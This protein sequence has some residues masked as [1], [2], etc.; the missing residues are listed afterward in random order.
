MSVLNLDQVLHKLQIPTATEIF[1]SFWEES[2]AGMPAMVPD[3]LRPEVA[4]SYREWCG[5]SPEA[6]EALVETCKRIQEDSALMQFTWHCHQLMYKHPEY[7][8][9]GQWPILTAVLGNLAGVV[10]LLV[11]LAAT[12]Y[13]QSV[14]QKLGVSAEITR[15]TCHQVAC[16]ATNYYNM[17][18]GLF[19][20][21]LNQI[22]WLRNYTNG[23]LFRIGRF[24]YRIRSFGSWLEAY[25]NK[26]TRQV[27]ALSV[28]GARYTV[29]GY[30]AVDDVAD[31]WTAT[32]LHNQD[33]V[34]GY[35]IL[36]QGMAENRLVTLAL[37]Q[38]ER[39][40]QQGDLVLDMHIPTG[41]AMHLNDCADSFRKGVAF[42]KHFFPEKPIKAICCNN[43]WIFNNQLQEIT[44]SSD[45]LAS[46]QR[47]LYLFPIKSSVDSG[48]WFIFQQT[49]LDLNTAP[50]RTSLQRAVAD[51]I[52]SGHTWRSGGMYF[53]VDDLDQFGTQVYRNALLPAV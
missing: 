53:L 9:T 33:T 19:G 38:W 27:I 11:G 12:P 35:P 51:Y 21:T 37:D 2:M 22:Y 3:F 41:G 14:H 50:R 47:E 32:L 44:L 34:A 4:V 20:I 5:M 25:R 30:V 36:P 43:S 10:Y 8:Q 45:N 28:D 1:Q 48:L 6:D 24:E 13:V 39:V 40:L 16:F 15:A 7:S 42:F 31:A 23:Q 52:L 26:E 46:F 17:T 49:P 18:N 29:D